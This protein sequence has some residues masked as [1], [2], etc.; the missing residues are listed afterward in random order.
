MQDVS[1]EDEKVR[2]ERV[3]L[4][5]AVFAIDPS[6]RHS[7]EHDR[8][9][10][11]GKEGGYPLDPFQGETPVREQL[12]EGGPSDGVESLTE[13]K[14]KNHCVRFPSVA[15]VKQVCCIDKIL[16]NR[17]PINEACLVIVDEHRD[18]WF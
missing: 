1:N 15:A 7:I 11:G 10:A 2:G 5:K 14:F 18:K 9:F 3:A 8:S 6:S 17:S 16:S 13:V 12:Q 4:S